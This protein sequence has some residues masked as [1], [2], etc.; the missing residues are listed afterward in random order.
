MGNTLEETVGGNSLRFKSQ[1]N[2]KE[3]LNVQLPFNPEAIDRLAHFF[4][5]L[6]SV[7]LPEPSLQ[8]SNE[9]SGEERFTE[10]S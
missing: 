7:K 1:A 6:A 10:Q 8:E 4:V 2:D 5:L 3:D 9:K